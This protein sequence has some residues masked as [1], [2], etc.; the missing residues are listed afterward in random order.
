LGDPAY[1]RLD[2]PATAGEKNRLARLDPSQLGITQLAGEPVQAMLTRAAGNGAPIG[3]LKV[4]AAHGWFAVRPS[5]TENILKMYAESFRGDEH[6]GQIIEE[7]ESTL[8]VALGDTG[9]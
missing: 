1:R 9:S 7:A 5:G 8:S 2:M 4:V 6:L 3:G